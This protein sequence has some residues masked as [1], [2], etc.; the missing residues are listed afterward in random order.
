MTPS[1]I[2][3]TSQSGIAPINL[4][5]HSLNSI[6]H[7]P[8]SAIEKVT[9][10]TLPDTNYLLNTGVFRTMDQLKFLPDQPYG[11]ILSSTEHNPEKNITTSTLKIDNISLVS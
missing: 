9:K 6:R 2:Y 1:K 4:E 3:G 5:R 11:D 10:E 7:S 8:K